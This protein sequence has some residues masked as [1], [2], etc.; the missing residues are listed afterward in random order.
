MNELCNNF[1]YSQNNNN[2][3]YMYCAHVQKADKY[4]I[5]LLFSPPQ[6]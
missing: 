5:P 6:C 2:D 3:K 1:K 4:G